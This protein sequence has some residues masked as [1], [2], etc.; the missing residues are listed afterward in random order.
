MMMREGT[1]GLHHSS[2]FF[3]RSIADAGTPNWMVELERPTNGWECLGRAGPFGP[4]HPCQHVLFSV[5]YTSLDRTK[6]LRTCCKHSGFPISYE[7]VLG[8]QGT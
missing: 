1:L 5:R 2:P 7:V 4:R 3:V 8:L 6:V